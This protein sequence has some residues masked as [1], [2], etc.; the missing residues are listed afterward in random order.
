MNRSIFSRK[1]TWGVKARRTGNLKYRPLIVETL[2]TRRFMSAFSPLQSAALETGSGAVNLSDEMVSSSAFFAPQ[3]PIAVSR[4][5]N[6]SQG[7]AAADLVELNVIP[8]AS[9]KSAGQEMP[10]LSAVSGTEEAMQIAMNSDSNF[11]LGEGGTVNPL[12]PEIL[13]IPPGDAGGLAGGNGGGRLPLEIPGFSGYGNAYYLTDMTSMPRA[14]WLYAQY[15]GNQQR[16]VPEMTVL[17]RAASDFSAGSS[18]VFGTSLGFPISYS[19]LSGSDRQE[20]KDGEEEEKEESEETPEIQERKIEHFIQ[21]EMD[22]KLLDLLERKKFFEKQRSPLKYQLQKPVFP[23]NVPIPKDWP[24]RK[25]TA[26]LDE[27]GDS[28]L[29]GETDYPEREFS[30]DDWHWIDTFFGKGTEIGTDPLAEKKNTGI[31][32]AWDES[33]RRTDE[34]ITDSLFRTDCFSGFGRGFPLK[35]TADNEPDFFSRFPQSMKS[36]LKRSESTFFPSRE[37]G[38]E[39]RPQDEVKIELPSRNLSLSPLALPEVR[40][41]L[42]KPETDFENQSQ[43]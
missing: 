21:E 31:F 9:P 37:N 3:V 23:E 43:D 5:E 11:N 4:E 15:F 35:N 7:S 2:E 18:G 1:Q 13:G 29:P 14:V 40:Q 10:R 39:R 30:P 38:L 20:S 36:F 12:A 33:S 28:E 16:V 17:P 24:G 19:E 8:A 22:R 25:E 34:K 41:I 26:P 6:V 42:P 27:G 32:S